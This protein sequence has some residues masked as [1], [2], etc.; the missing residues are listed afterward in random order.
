MKTLNMKTLKLKGWP[1]RATIGRCSA[2]LLIAAGMQTLSLP[3]LQAATP[4]KEITDSGITS[5]VEDGLTHEKG[6]SVARFV[7][8]FWE[9][10]CCSMLLS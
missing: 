3:P 6:G 1:R 4:P 10:P 7:G 5:V 2:I 8:D 9:F